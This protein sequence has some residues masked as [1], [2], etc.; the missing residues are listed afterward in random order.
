MKSGRRDNRVNID[1]LTKRERSILD[2]WDEGHGSRS[3][4]RILGLS[5][6]QAKRSI[7][8][9]VDSGDHRNY[10]DDMIAGSLELGRRFAAERLAMLERQMAAAA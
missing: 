10:R 7:A 6:D 9:L 5:E 2:L 4:A 3:I 8:S 1:G